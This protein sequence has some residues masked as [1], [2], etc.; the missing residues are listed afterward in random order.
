MN[1][2][3]HTNDPSHIIEFIKLAIKFK[4][5]SIQIFLGDRIKTTLKYKHSFSKEDIQAIKELTKKHKIKLFIH[6]LLS[7][8]F[9]NDPKSSRYKWGLTNLIYDLQLAHKLGAQGVTIHAGRY[10]TKRY[11]ISPK[12]C[13]KHYIDSLKY[14]IDQT[15]NLNIP[16]LIETPATKKNTI[17]YSLEEFSEFY[18]LI[19]ENYKKRIKIC[20][21]ICHIFVSNHNIS[22]KEGIL[23]YFKTF[24]KLIGI[25]NIKLI[26]LND[27]YGELN[28]H[29][30]RHAPLGKGFIFKNNNQ[31]N[32][33]ELIKISTKYKIPMI[34]ETN[35]ETFHKNIALLKHIKIGGNTKKININKKDLILSIFQDLL[36]YYK[37]L[38]QSK[39]KIFRIQSYEKL[40][41]QLIK[42][43]KIS[44]I[45]NL[46][47][48]EGLG[49]KS[50]NKIKE[51]LKTNKLKQHNNIKKNLNKIK[52]LKNFQ[53]IYGIGPVQAQKLKN[54]GIKNIKQL[55]K[56][57][58]N[59]E[60]ELTN[61][62]KLYLNYY[63]NLIK[64]IPKEEI[65]KISQQLKKDLKENK[66]NVQFINAG[67]YAMKKNYSGD[68]DIIL[69]FKKENYTYQ[70]L[71]NKIHH[72]FNKKKY[73]KGNL[74]NGSQKDIFVFQLNKDSK[75]HQ[76]DIAYVEEK[77]K[78]FYILYFSSSRD[79]SKKIRLL[80]SKKGYKLNEKGLYDKSG[81]LIDFQPKSEKDIFKY[82]E[83]P[84]VLPENRI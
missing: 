43:K 65:T 4:C 69:L 59:K 10:N 12:Q 19:P 63:E 75:V 76:M 74:L 64:K 35:S 6:G 77:H 11:S 62:Q 28:S 71:K 18:N 36:H 68:I 5:N 58:K 27:S 84:Y 9:C 66:I 32:L 79:F 33:A 1:Y 37:T 57:V 2:G 46:N 51:I 21:D 20:V 82:L 61:A 14:V 67:S 41:K 54:K 48:V 15:S 26:H 49:Q 72:L 55:K 16:I 53:N 83:I 70:Q 39:E 7:L 22:S 47:K 81:K 31:E 60:I 13:Y 25:K 56:S 17:I 50:K 44:S 73:S 30:N 29:L 42:L 45:K 40:I 52:T 8:N 78:Y 24:N 23:N 34:L 3:I 38:N 80:A